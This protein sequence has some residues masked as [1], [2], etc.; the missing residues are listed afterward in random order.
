LVR[1]PRYFSNA[2]ETHESS[3]GLYTTTGSVFRTG[4]GGGN[5]AALGLSGRS[6]RFNDAAARREIIIHGADY[7]TDAGAGRSWGCPAISRGRAERLLPQLG[8][9][10]V[11]YSFSP[12]DSDF[13]RNEPWANR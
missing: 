3:L 4:A 7:V 8:A 10:A 2:D 9:G 6:G 12:H 11:L 1:P 13:M 5:N